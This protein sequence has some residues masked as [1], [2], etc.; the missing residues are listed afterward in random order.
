MVDE[1]GIGKAAEHRVR[2]AVNDVVGSVEDVCELPVTDVVVRLVSPK[3]AARHFAKFARSV[4]AGEHILA[5]DATDK[6]RQVVRMA[7]RMLPGFLYAV[8]R[9]MW[10]V[11]NGQT[12]QGTDG[13]PEI[14]VLPRVWSHQR[15]TDNLLRM[16]MAHELGHVV[17]NGSAPWVAARCRTLLEAKADLPEVSI[18]AEGHATWVHRRVSEQVLGSIPHPGKSSLRTRGTVLLCRCLPVLPP[19]R[20]YEEGEQ[21]VSKAVAHGGIGMVNRAWADPSLVPTASEIADPGQWVTRVK[22]TA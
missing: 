22:A 19:Q 12:I 13:T 9:V 1:V 5:P 18:F 20:N 4:F 7:S 6:E 21:F 15:T 10:P 17:Q 2:S 14:L 16:Y 11:I 3:Q 8:R